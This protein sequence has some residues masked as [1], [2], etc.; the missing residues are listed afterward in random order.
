MICDNCKGEMGMY[1]VDSEAKRCL[2]P[3]CAKK[4]LKTDPSQE[5]K[6]T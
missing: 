6:E 1:I 2:C 4:L 5:A 3:K